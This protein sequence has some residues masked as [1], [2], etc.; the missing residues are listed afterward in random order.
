MDTNIILLIV[1]L[2]QSSNS[3]NNDQIHMITDYFKG[4]E[5]KPDYT[6]E[7]VKLIKKHTSIS[8][9]RIWKSSS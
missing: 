1:F 6:K 5:I 4:M 3:S 8:S 2:L 7:K 9:R